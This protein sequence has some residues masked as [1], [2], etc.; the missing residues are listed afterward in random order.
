MHR[1]DVAARVSSLLRHIEAWRQAPGQGN[2]GQVRAVLRRD[3]GDPFL[4]P[5]RDVDKSRD[6][7]QG[8]QGPEAD[9]HGLQRQHVPLAVEDRRL[10]LPRP[11]QPHVEEGLRAEGPGLRQHIAL[12][13]EAAVRGAED[14]AALLAEVIDLE[15][16]H[17]ERNLLVLRQNRQLH[18]VDGDGYQLLR[19]GLQG[20]DEAEVEAGQE[21][22]HRQPRVLLSDR[23]VLHR[24]VP[25]LRPASRGRRP[26][27]RRL[28][29]GRR[30]GRRVRRRGVV[31][32]RR[33]VAEHEDAG[34]AAVPE[35]DLERRRAVAGNVEILSVLRREVMEL[36]P[37]DETLAR[38]KDA[39]YQLPRRVGVREDEV[40]ALARLQAPLV[41]GVAAGQLEGDG[42]R[43][44][45]VLDAIG[46]AALD[47][48]DEHRGPDE[49]HTGPHDAERILPG[50]RAQAE[51]R[52]AH[53][54]ER[55]LNRPRRR[56]AAAAA[57]AAAAV[58]GT[59]TASTACDP[60]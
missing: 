12:G 39:A 13:V 40:P 26:G 7:Q 8:L 41:R 56:S 18:V 60:H 4:Q 17:G 49:L 11:G 24:A 19:R 14:E 31:C 22:V 51:H 25:L 28:G 57:A 6:V 37:G 34:R 38:A 46:P 30:R 16:V 58:L 33:R 23:Q 43:L 27:R 5:E 44:G 50:A 9:L 15:V 3:A 21:D 45:A 2:L 55:E 47:Q 42:V 53:G 29:R 52:V 59:T 35:P 48:D 36:K 1:V 10:R 20:V 54:R 32:L